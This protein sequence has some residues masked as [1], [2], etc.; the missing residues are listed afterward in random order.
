M[1]ENGIT[2]IGNLSGISR[3]SMQL[4]F[5]VAL[6]ASC[7]ADR[8]VRCFRLQIS[9]YHFAAILYSIVGSLGSTAQ[10]H[11]ARSGK[12]R[13]GVIGQEVLAFDFSRTA[14][15]A[16]EDICTDFFDIRFPYAGIVENHCIGSDEL[17]GCD[18]AYTVDSDF[19][20]FGFGLLC[21]VEFADTFE[22][23]FQLVLAGDV[24][25]GRYVTD[26]AGVYFQPVSRQ[27]VGQLQ[28]GHAVHFHFLQLRRADDDVEYV[29]RNV[30]VLP[31]VYGQRFVFH[32]D[33]HH[34]ENVVRGADADAGL[35]GIF[36]AYVA[37]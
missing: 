7:I 36:I 9:G 27:V 17:A 10:F 11:G 20:I 16:V 5:R 15:V 4:L 12:L 28:I 30:D 33:C 31:K 8:G 19:D 32:L 26:A 2:G 21:Q 22:I 6:N 14:D 34:I 1:V 37:V 25:I 24:A 29:Q 35:P 3:S 13:S 18:M 23:E